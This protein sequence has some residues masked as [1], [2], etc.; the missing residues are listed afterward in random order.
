METYHLIIDE[1]DY[2]R[3]AI[4]NMIEARSYFDTNSYDDDLIL[5]EFDS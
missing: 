2:S 1:T 4:E 3:D 5:K